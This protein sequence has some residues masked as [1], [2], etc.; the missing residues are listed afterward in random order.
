MDKSVLIVHVLGNGNSD[1]ISFAI[2]LKLPLYLPIVKS[3]N[4]SLTDGFLG[5]K[6]S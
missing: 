2:D 3:E 4:V 1:S 6:G 5:G